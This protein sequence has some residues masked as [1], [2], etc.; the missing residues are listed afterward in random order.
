MH[1]MKFMKRRI[2][3][4]VTFATTPGESLTLEGPVRYGKGDALMTGS[5]GEHWPISRLTFKATYDPVAPTQM[6]KAGSYVKKPIPVAARQLDQKDS[7]ALEESRGELRGKIGDW[8]VTG[9]DGKQWVV[10]D[11]IFKDTYRVLGDD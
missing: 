3:V 4:N 7:V 2:L 8:V 9:P 10:A 1:V 5:A 6:G 11:T